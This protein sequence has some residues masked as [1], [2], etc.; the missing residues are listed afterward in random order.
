MQRVDNTK[1]SETFSPEVVEY[2]YYYDETEKKRVFGQVG[3]RNVYLD[4]QAHANE[5]DIKYI[6]ELLLGGGAPELT[7]DMYADVSHISNDLLENLMQAEYARD[8][9]N[10][11]PMPIRE[12]YS[13]DFH[14]FAKDFKMSDFDELIKSK[15][16]RKPVVETPKPNN[17]G[18]EA[19]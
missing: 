19:K 8:C 9:F 16:E 13:N 18:K 7:P 17:D 4:I 10:N 5:T 15:L 6:K 3:K 2:G 11:L 14:T 12:K 1:F